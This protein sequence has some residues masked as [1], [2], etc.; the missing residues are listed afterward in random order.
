MD[1][2]KIRFKLEGCCI[3]SSF[4]Q[5]LFFFLYAVKLHRKPTFKKKK[6][7]RALV[8]SKKRVLSIEKLWTSVKVDKQTT[9]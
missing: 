4:P 8:E 5:I 6:K 7:G 9:F 1:E 2:I 3:I